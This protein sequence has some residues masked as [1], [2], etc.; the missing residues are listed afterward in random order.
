VTHKS[1]VLVVGAGPAGLATA[2]AASLKGFSVAVADSRK[3]PIEKACGEGLLPEAVAN[4]RRLGIDLSL[5]AAFPFKGIRFSDDESSASTRIKRGTAFGLRRISLHNLLVQRACELGVT[6]LW[7]ARVSD[8]D[9][10]GARVNGAAFRCRWL[11]GA[12]GQNSGVRKWA[13]LNPRRPRLSRFGFSRHYAVTPWTD[14]VEVH[15]GPHC[16]L[17]ATPTGANE[18]CVALLSHNPQLRIEPALAYFPEVAARLRDAL[19]LSAEIGSVTELGSA[20]AVAR[21]R[22][23][24]VGDASFTV[25]GIAGQGLSLA[26]EQAAQLAEAFARDD[27]SYYER[28]HRKISRTPRRMTRLLLLMD[29][30]AWIRRKTLR[31]FARNPGLF[32][33]MMSQHLGEAE[34]NDLRT[35]EI[36]GLGWQVLRA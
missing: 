32:S 14:M 22:V 12:D 26:F 28:A 16:Q 18:V 29:Q 1:D 8:F 7:G 23:A 10:H 21:G 33:K 31:L 36:L 19:P 3:P 5:S 17:F 15:W 11:V 34:Q 20:Q 13:S 24:L 27:L 35:S 30:S 4:L 9:S 2:I 25:D 6:F